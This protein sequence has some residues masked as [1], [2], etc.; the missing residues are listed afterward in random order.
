[1]KVFTFVSL[2]A[3]ALGSNVAS[4]ADSGTHSVNV[5]LTPPPMTLNMTGTA[6]NTT[7]DIDFDRDKQYGVS[8]VST[9]YYISKNLGDVTI[10]GSHIPSKITHCSLSFTSN[11]N[12][13]V[14]NEYNYSQ[15][16][17]LYLDGYTDFGYSNALRFFRAFGTGNPDDQTSPILDAI[18]SSGTCNIKAFL[19]FYTAFPISPRPKEGIYHDQIN[20]LLTVL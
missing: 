4:A 3:L 1:M 8:P 12:W 9:Y 2:L 20:F 19:R 18:D 7:S 15:Q 10:A 6:F 17:Y 11:N 16:Y 5:Q 14:I 13:R